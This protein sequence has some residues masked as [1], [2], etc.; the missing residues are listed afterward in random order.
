ML[1]EWLKQKNYQ[2]K[3]A[4]QVSTLLRYNDNNNSDNNDSK[5]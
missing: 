5:I 4:A 3:L 2:M 1:I